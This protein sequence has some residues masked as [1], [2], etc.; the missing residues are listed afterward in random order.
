MKKNICICYKKHSKRRHRRRRG[1]GRPGPSARRG[2]GAAAREGAVFPR[3]VAR[4][5]EGRE[6]GAADGRGRDASGRDRQ[7]GGVP[8][9]RAVSVQRLRGRHR[10]VLRRGR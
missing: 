10:G 1:L 8:P 7:R 4:G 6:R 5:E 2:V 3:A 9:S